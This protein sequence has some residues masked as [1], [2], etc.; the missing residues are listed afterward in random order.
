MGFILQADTAPL[1]PPP[2]PHRTPAAVSPAAPPSPDRPCTGVSGRRD[3]GS[4]VG[5]PGSTRQR[6]TTP[7]SWGSPSPTPAEGQVRKHLIGTGDILVS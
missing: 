3:S 2:L 4:T 1:P 7:A 6:H 5:L